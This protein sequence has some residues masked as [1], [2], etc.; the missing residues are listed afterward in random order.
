MFDEHDDIKRR[1]GCSSEGLAEIRVAF[2][3]SVTTLW[4]FIGYHVEEHAER[5]GQMLAS[6]DKRLRIYIV[7][8]IFV[9]VAYSILT[10]ILVDDLAVPESDYYA[11]SDA[12]VSTLFHEGFPAFFN[13]V[14]YFGYHMVEAAFILVGMTFVQASAAACATFNALTA[15]VVLWFAFV[16]IDRKANVAVPLVVSVAL[17]FVTAIRFPAFSLE[18]Y[19]GQGSPTIWHNPTYYA[20]KPFAL[21]SMGL[22]LKLAKESFSDKR[23]CVVLSILI[24]VGV[25][26]KPVFFQCFFPAVIAIYALRAIVKDRMPARVLLVFAP[27]VVLGCVMVLLLFFQPSTDGSGGGGGIAVTFF[28]GWSP[29]SNNPWVSMALLFAF[30]IY[31]MAINWRSFFTLRGDKVVVPATL[32][33]AWLEQ[34]LLVETGD[35]AAHGNFGWGTCLAT[36]LAWVYGLTAFANNTV[37]RDKPW[38]V[39]LIGWLLVAWHFI[40]GVY[41]IYHLFSTS[42]LC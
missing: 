16:L 36:F 21:L 19:L 30:P 25:L 42:M 26:M 31:S 10:F 33:V 38:P 13:R 2:E 8:S 14:P 28:G 7:A 4:W 12:I 6:E 32:L 17:L 40:S 22:F 5:M 24:L 27:S 35:R 11:H 15:G 34:M 39:L 37:R 18:V 41:Y 1:L 29:F 3:I 23:G 20:I 9:V